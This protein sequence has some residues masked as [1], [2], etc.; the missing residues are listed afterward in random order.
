MALDQAR[1]RPHLRAGAGSGL[2]HHDVPDREHRG[3]AGEARSRLPLTAGG[4]W[5]ALRG[6]PVVAR[7]VSGASPGTQPELALVAKEGCL[8]R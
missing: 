7:G 5:R 4:D 3:E 2:A 8:Q 6:L 1:L